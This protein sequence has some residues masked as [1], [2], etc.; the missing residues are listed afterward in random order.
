MRGVT[1]IDAMI[2]LPDAPIL[3]IDDE[4]D[5]REA[6]V[7]VLENEGYRAVGANN[8]RVAYDLL[9][10][11]SV[12]PCIIVLDLMMPVMDGWGFRAVQMCDPQLASI[13][14]IVLSAAGRFDVAAAAESL[15]AVA[16]MEKPVDWD[17]LLGLV[18]EHCQRPTMH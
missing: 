4:P 6:A 17:E 16:G 1:Y 5:V 7:A 13:P 15:R 2:A 8:G 14:V 18:E 12:R 9:R 10:T 11:G 3:V